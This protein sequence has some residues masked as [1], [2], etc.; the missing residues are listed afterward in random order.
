[1]TK[2]VLALLLSAALLLTACGKASKDAPEDAVAL[3]RY[4]EQEWTLPVTETNSELIAPHLSPDGKISIIAYTQDSGAISSERYFTTADGQI[5]ME[6]EPAWLETLSGPETYINS[7]HFNSK[8]E[9]VAVYYGKRLDGSGD[10]GYRCAMIKPDGTVTDSEIGGP[11]PWNDRNVYYTTIPQSESD[12]SSEAP[13]A[14]VSD[15]DATEAVSAAA[16]GDLAAEG[17]A[18]EAVEDVQP[19]PYTQQLSIASAIMGEDG[20]VYIMTHFSGSGKFDPATGKLMTSFLESASATAVTNTEVVQLLTPNSAEIAGQSIETHSLFYSDIKTGEINRVL[21]VPGLSLANSVTMASGGDGAVYITDATGL[22]RVAPGGETLELILDGGLC[23]LSMPSVRPYVLIPH[24]ENEF[25]IPFFGSNYGMNGNNLLANF[26]YSA[27][28]PSQPDSELTIF[29]MMQNR[30]VSQAIGVF[31]KKYPNTI[32]N[33]RTG[34]EIAEGGNGDDARRTLNNQILAGDGPDLFVLEGLPVQSFIEKGV[35]LD[36]S[37]VI[38]PMLDAGEILPAVTMAYR[39]DDWIYAVPARVKLPTLWGGEEAVAAANDL[40]SLLAFARQHPGERLFGNMTPGHLLYYLMDGEWSKL[41]KEDGV[42][43]AEVE[44][45]LS[46]V[47]ELS[48]T[49][50]TPHIYEYFGSESHLSQ[51]NFNSQNGDWADAESTEPMEDLY[52]V[53]NNRAALMPVTL[54]GFQSVMSPNGIINKRIGGMTW[55]VTGEGDWNSDLPDEI[56]DKVFR[57]FPEGGW[58]EPACVLGVNAASEQNELALAFVE[59]VLS[60]E[61][62]TAD[63]EDGF[64]VNRAAIAANVERKESWYTSSNFNVTTDDAALALSAQEL[65]TE[66]TLE[67]A[68]PS[69]AMLQAVADRLEEIE[70]PIMANYPLGVYYGMRECLPIALEEVVSGKATAREAAEWLAAELSLALEE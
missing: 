28:T 69:K 38:Q 65:V 5:W 36:L 27:E 35:L 20:M 31:R 24:G 21:P 15:D 51:Y 70:R 50:A 42:D 56:V 64:P 43:A 16:S 62:Q 41:L 10:D 6:E 54:N 67:Y 19:G 18:S 47:I 60:A 17:A 30:T 1:M 3:G 49:A 4:I 53:S 66:L 61:T 34:D 12:E 33:I 29:S 58:Y 26:V 52:A 9:G 48:K 40:D 2:K 13:V 39:Q 63:L 44:K 7:I 23:S 46:V 57:L 14:V 45:L 55:D 22:Y 68:W 37:S 11:D 25:F 59:A 8:G 32:V